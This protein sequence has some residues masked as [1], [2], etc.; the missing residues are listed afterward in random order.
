MET[1]AARRAPCINANKG[2]IMRKVLRPVWSNDKQVDDLCKTMYLIV[3]DSASHAI[4]H[5][6]KIVT[7]PTG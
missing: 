5:V 7:L 6:N 4:L 1:R 3:N 2:F